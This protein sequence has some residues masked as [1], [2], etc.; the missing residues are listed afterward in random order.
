MHNKTFTVDGR[1][2][3]TGGR[4]IADEYFDY[5][6]EYNFRDRDVLLLGKVVSQVENSFELFW[7]NKLSV[8]VKN[9]IDSDSEKFDSSIYHKLHQYA[10]NPMN[11]WPQVR[12]RI[13]KL[14]EAFKQMEPMVCKEVALQLIRLYI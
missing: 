8:D 12:E 9:L 10:C 1:I 3:I 11:F 14:Q 4:N 5:D 2:T 13:Q 7:N 6:H